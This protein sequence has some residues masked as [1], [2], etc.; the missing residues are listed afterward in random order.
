MGRTHNV[1]GHVWTPHDITVP[2]RGCQHTKHSQ[3]SGGQNKQPLTRASSMGKIIGS[4]MNIQRAVFNCLDDGINNALKVLND[5]ALTGWNASMD[6]REMFDQI[7]VTYWRPTPA[8]LLQ[9]DTLFRSA[10][11][12]QDAPEMLFRRIKD[13]QEVQILGEDQYT[14]QQLL[15]NAVCLLLQTGIHP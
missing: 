3:P 13:C 11:S 5:P 8:A 15:N 14:A 10:H 9:N 7:T 12:P 6:P 4:R 2:A 1:Q